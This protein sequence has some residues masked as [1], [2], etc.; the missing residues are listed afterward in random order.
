MWL[1]NEDFQPIISI[2]KSRQGEDTGRKVPPADVQ[3]VRR[4]FW[5]KGQKILAVYHCDGAKESWGCHC[6]MRY[7][8]RRRKENGPITTYQHPRQVITCQFPCFLHRRTTAD[9]SM[10]ANPTG[11]YITKPTASP[12][13]VLGQRQRTRKKRGGAETG[14]GA[15]SN[16]SESSV[17][18]VRKFTTAFSLLWTLMERAGWNAYKG[19]PVP[20]LAEQWDALYGA[21]AGLKIPAIGKS[22]A[23]ISWMPIPSKYVDR[24]ET[25]QSHVLQN[26]ESATYEPEGYAFF[27][28]EEFPDLGRISTLCGDY[29]TVAERART[30]AR[31]PQ[32]YANIARDRMLRRGL[33]GPYINLLVGRIERG[34]PDASPLNALRHVAQAVLDE[35]WLMPVESNYEREAA[36]L[37]QDLGIPF[38]KPLFAAGDMRPDFI[39]PQARVVL[40]VQGMTTPEYLRDK[41]LVLARVRDWCKRKGM[42]LEEWNPNKSEPISVL[43]EI[44]KKY[45]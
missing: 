34:E 26:W 33:T 16:A 19:G 37:L 39:L 25:L 32:Y 28:T 24:N 5:D 11:L 15:G 29:I 42:T 31:I 44:L 1:E 21:A 12:G 9:V 22:Y 27:F 17:R 10:E 7:N 40:E 3:T 38:T 4:D 2:L 36:W 41:P 23:D 6:G 14:G 13:L 35:N 20:S 18:R 8:F 45:V 30:D 43:K